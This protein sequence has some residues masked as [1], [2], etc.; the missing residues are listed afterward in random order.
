MEDQEQSN[1]EISEKH[2]TEEEKP[3]VEETKTKQKKKKK[4]NKKCGDT[5]Q[6]LPPMESET[7][8]VEDEPNLDDAP[9]RA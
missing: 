9:Q 8:I 4:A 5:P 1:T 6:D 7:Y 3:V 2:D